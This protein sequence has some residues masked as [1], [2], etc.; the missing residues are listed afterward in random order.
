M[1]SEN[2]DI[3]NEEKKLVPIPDSLILAVLNKME[4]LK[5]MIDEANQALADAPENVKAFII[6]GLEN[7]KRNYMRAEQICNNIN[8]VWTPEDVEFIKNFLNS[9]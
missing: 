2:K 5:G 7:D 8:R 4:F 3:K 9:I 6:A 1:N